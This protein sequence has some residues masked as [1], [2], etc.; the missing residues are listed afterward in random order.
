M[1]Q[2]QP[3]LVADGQENPLGTI[4]ANKMHEVQKHC[5]MTAIWSHSIHATAGDG[6]GAPGC[7]NNP[8]T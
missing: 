1:T 2:R 3:G 7:R 6:S 5:S 8:A 4:E